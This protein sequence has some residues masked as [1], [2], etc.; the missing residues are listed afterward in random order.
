[1]LRHDEGLEIS[2][3]RE[4]VAEEHLNRRAG[5]IVSTR[6]LVTFHATIVAKNRATSSRAGI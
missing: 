3:A 5:R 1:M 6:V 2:T 4:Y